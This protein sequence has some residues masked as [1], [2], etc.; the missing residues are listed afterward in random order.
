MG[1]IFVF[2]KSDIYREEFKGYFYIIFK[3]VLGW[4]GLNISWELIK[5][6]EEN[7]VVN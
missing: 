1:G 6:R 3:L 7:L 2:I 4:F 5:L